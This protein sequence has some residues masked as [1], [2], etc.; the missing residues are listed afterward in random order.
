MKRCTFICLL[1]LLGGITEI[2]SGSDTI[3][4][5]QIIRCKNYRAE[6]NLN[7]GG[8]CISLKHLPTD[9]EVLRTTT[10]RQE[11]EK[12]PLLYGMPIL[13]F[14]NR[15]AG[16][17]FIFE[18]RKY[19]WPLNEPER[20]NSIHGNLYQTSFRLI[21]K[22][23][24]SIEMEYAASEDEPYLMF[25]HPFVLRLCYRVDS[26]GLHQQ[27]RV[28]NKSLFNMPF[29]IAFHT[30]FNIPFIPDSKVGD[31]HLTLP[32]CQKYPRDSFTLIPTGECLS[33][34]PLQEELNTGTLVP[35]EH[36]LS[37][38][39]SRDSNKAMHLTDISS[40][41]VIT[42]TADS[43]HRFWMLWNGGEDNLLTVEPQTCLIDA[44]NVN[45]PNAE[46]GIIVIKTGETI[47]LNTRIN[48]H[49]RNF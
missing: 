10:S 15:I 40:G 17:Q 48:V 43:L 5:N 47:E 22:T 32:V 14:P 1:I 23:Q 2:T 4:C 31:V 33:S 26:E 9:I 18:G 38:F 20:N 21:K 46:K 39:Y 25:P 13:F 28:T 42:Y 45:R 6:I 37:D 3:L 41:W 35:H 44:F 8:N 49:N 34:F 27:V 24:C 7:Y 11:L 36:T 19:L 30:T 12:T 29:G 16:A